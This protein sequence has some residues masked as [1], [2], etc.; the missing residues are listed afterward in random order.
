M[1]G[2]TINAFSPVEGSI[3]SRNTPITF[4]VFG[5][6]LLGAPRSVVISVIAGGSSVEELVFGGVNFTA[7]YTGGS[8]NRLNITDGYEFTIL[9]LGGW[10][11]TSITMRIVAVDQN[12]DVAR[13]TLLLPEALYTWQLVDRAGNVTPFV[14][15]R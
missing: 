2:P 5:T 1:S 4:Q 7:S 9:R 13:K 11:G 3:L 6:A 15:G 12:G 14:G 8:N 10:R